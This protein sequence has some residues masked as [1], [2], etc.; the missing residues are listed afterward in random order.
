[1]KNHGLYM[2]RPTRLL[3]H[4]CNHHHPHPHPPPPHHHDHDH[5][6]IIIIIT[7]MMKKKKKKKKKKNKKKNNKNKN[8]NKN[9]MM[10]MMMMM[11]MVDD[12]GSHIHLILRVHRHGPS[13]NTQAFRNSGAEQRQGCTVHVYTSHKKGN[14]WRMVDLIALLTSNHP[15]PALND[16]GAVNS[17]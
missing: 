14:L 3:L 6:L 16:P 5:D 12:H 1:M 9:M 11:M 4:P 7:I 10:M 17:A 13:K 2:F 15:I 8:K